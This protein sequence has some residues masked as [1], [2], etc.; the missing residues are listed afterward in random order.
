MRS[1]EE[2]GENDNVNDGDEHTIL[3]FEVLEDLWPRL[4]HKARAE[5]L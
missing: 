3:E 1:P 2:D 5:T 4:L